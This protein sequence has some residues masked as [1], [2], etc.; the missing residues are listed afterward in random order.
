MKSGNPKLTAL[1]SIDD[2][3]G[4]EMV[5][6][7]LRKA[8]G[9]VSDAAKALGIDRRNLHKWLEVYPKLAKEHRAIRKAAKP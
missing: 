6:E 8:E 9:N 4:H 7:A 1:L 2:P 3:R 5:I